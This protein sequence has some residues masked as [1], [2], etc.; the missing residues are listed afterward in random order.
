MFWTIVTMWH[1]SIKIHI[2][3]WWTAQKKPLY[4]SLPKTPKKSYLDRWWWCESAA[5]DV[6]F[7]L[8]GDPADAGPAVLIQLWE[9]FEAVQISG[10][11]GSFLMGSLLANGVSLVDVVDAAHLQVV[12]AVSGRGEQR[13]KG[14]DE[15]EQ[16]HCLIKKLLLLI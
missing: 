5:L 7:L 8:L 3:S 10:N 4:P 9:V 1:L 11:I 2:L 13:Q 14:E 6:P 12:G 16:F 15:H